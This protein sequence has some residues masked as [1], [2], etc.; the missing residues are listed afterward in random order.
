MK[1][2]L[3]L[4]EKLCKAPGAP[5]REERIRELVRGQLEGLCDEVTTDVLGNVIGHRRATVTRG[6]NGQTQGGVD[7]PRRLMLSCHMDEIAFLVTHVDDRGF[8]RFTTLGGFDPKTLTAQRVWVHGR[9]DLLGVMGT[10]PVHILT[11]EERRAAPKVD[12]YFVDVGLP[13]E[14]VSAQVSIGDVIT[15]EREVVE[16]G[17]MVSGK[18]FDNRIGVFVVLEALRRIGDHECDIYAA[19]TVQEEIGLRGA[20]VAARNIDPDI[21]IAL[22][23][24]VANDVPEAKPQQYCTRLGSGAAIKIMDSSVVCH[25]GVVRLLDTVA[26]ERNI[27]V[28]REVLVRGGTD[29]G[30]IQRSGSGA[31]AG[32]VSIPTRYVHSSI[33]MCAKA[34]VEAAI[35]LLTAF[36]EEVHR[37]SFAL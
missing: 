22:D 5:G 19:A 34:D 27:K 17:D 25:P 10:K 30:A 14:E 35:Q 9:R 11:D 37:E 32:C 4:L 33:E 13:P 1:F 8:V 36:I 24:T 28:Q 29:T 15:R 16:I 23:I 31:A 18:S 7:R 21:G 26:T 2:N 12:D 3:Q 6:G 20:T